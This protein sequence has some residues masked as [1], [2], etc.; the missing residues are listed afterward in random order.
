M[1]EKENR[2]MIDIKRDII[3]IYGNKN[4]PQGNPEAFEIRVSNMNNEVV[5]LYL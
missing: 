3:K 2:E 5:K 1:C 4:R